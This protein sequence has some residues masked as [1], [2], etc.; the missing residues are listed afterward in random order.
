MTDKPFTLSVKVVILDR[1]GRCLLIRRS[2]AS[3]GNP[4]KWDFPGGKLDPGETFDGGLLREVAEETGLTIRLERVLGA[5]ES[6]ARTKRVVYLLMEASHVSGR[7]RLS[8]EHDDFCWTKAGELP[9][10]DMAEQ[11]RDFAQSY[12]QSGQQ[13]T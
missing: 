2:M 12:A 7:V 5:A 9:S 6:E 10:A 1:K 3:E 8:E 4:G 11:F 13:S